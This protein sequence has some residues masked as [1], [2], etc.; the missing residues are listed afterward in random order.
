MLANLTQYPRITVQP[1]PFR[2][3]LLQMGYY[4]QLTSNFNNT[5][6]RENVLFL[7]YTL[8]IDSDTP[9]FT[10]ENTTLT[11]PVMYQVFQLAQ[12]L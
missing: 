3:A 5:A 7:E 11:E 2:L 8:S 10:E 6:P 12:T 9:Y 1:L 4:D